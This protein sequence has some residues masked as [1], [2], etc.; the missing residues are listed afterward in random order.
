MCLWRCFPVYWTLAIKPASSFS[1]CGPSGE[2]GTISDTLKRQLIFHFFLFDVLFLFTTNQTQSC[3]KNALEIY[4]FPKKCL[5]TIKAW[6]LLKG[7]AFILKIHKFN[8]LQKGWGFKIQYCI[9]PLLFFT[10]S[11][12]GFWKY[13]VFKNNYRG[14]LLS[15]FTGAVY[16]CSLL[17]LIWP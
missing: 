1:I 9:F 6:H 11:G 2:P 17:Q 12:W 3:F 7:F 13:L 16:E 14:T 4:F 8:C 10:L 15:E 5:Y